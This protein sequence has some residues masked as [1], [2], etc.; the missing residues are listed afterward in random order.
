V[1]ELPDTYEYEAH[2]LAK[3]LAERLNYSWQDIKFLTAGNVRL[4]YLI[5]DY[6]MPIELV[7]LGHIEGTVFY[8]D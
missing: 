6:R 5:T 7:R 3:F 8:R 1:I 2:K 4:V